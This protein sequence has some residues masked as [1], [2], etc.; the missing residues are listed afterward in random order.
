MFY[1]HMVKMDNNKCF[2]FFHLM[3]GISLGGMNFGSM[4]TSLHLSGS[5][6]PINQSGHLLENLGTI[7]SIEI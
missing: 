1:F 7:A 4:V 6:L 3:T 2:F 5:L